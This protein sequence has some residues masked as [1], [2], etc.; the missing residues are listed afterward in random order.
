MPMNS[1]LL[2][3]AT[4]VILCLSGIAIILHWRLYRLRQAQSR[5][6][7]LAMEKRVQQKL[8]IN[9]SIQVIARALLAD[10]VGATEASIR[11]SVLLDALNVQ[12]EV[13]DEFSAFYTLA[14]AASHIPI[15]DAWK[16]LPKHQRKAYDRDLSVLEEQHRDFVLDAAVRIQ[17]REL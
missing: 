16:A 17:G 13:K 12:A 9:R 5:A 6:A 14:E 11:I 8:S 15:L 3:A 2:I 7:V 10:Q 4:V 1:F